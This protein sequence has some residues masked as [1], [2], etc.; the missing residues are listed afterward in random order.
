V[1]R[2]IAGCCVAVLSTACAHV[3][4][5]N[6]LAAPAGL[7]VAPGPQVADHP[8]PFEMISSG[9]VQA[10]VPKQWNAAPIADDPLREG[11][12]ASPNLDGWATMDGTVPGLEAMWVDVG[13]VGIPFNYYYL[14]A[15][16]AAIPQVAT[17]RTCRSAHLEVIVDHRPVFA[18]DTWSA[19]DYAVRGSGSC[20]SRGHHTR[21]AYFVAAP[22]FGPVRH[23]GIPSS[24]LYVV[25]AVVQDSPD[26]AKRLRTMLMS[27][28]FDTTSVSQLIHAAKRSQLR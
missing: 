10:L 17:S 16:G 14:A 13:R 26:A 9:E 28:R 22:G 3:S 27:A 1:R 5:G 21:F 15:S 23:V 25:L 12:V 6:G 8:T 19:S 20:R 2:I 4:S 18:G 24:G 7:K 11:V